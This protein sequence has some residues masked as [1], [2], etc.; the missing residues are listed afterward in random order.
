M[1]IFTHFVVYRSIY[2]IVIKLASFLFTNKLHNGL[3]GSPVGQRLTSEWAC[4]LVKCVSPVR[5]RVLRCG[6][7]CG[8]RCCW[9][10]WWYR[11]VEGLPATAVLQ[12]PETG[13]VGLAE[14]VLS[15]E[16]ALPVNKAV[17]K[18]SSRFSG[19]KI[20]GFLIVCSFIIII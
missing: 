4:P 17:E 1:I 18:L 8:G 2:A 3:T 10:W 9:W 20:K 12:E 7:P 11:P 19:L 5:G 15:Q 6:R 14:V 13:G 16:L